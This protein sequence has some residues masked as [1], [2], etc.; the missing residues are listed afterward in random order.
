MLAHPNHPL[1]HIVGN[2]RGKH[3]ILV[4]DLSLTAGTLT[5]ASELLKREGAASVN[6][7]VTHCLLT[8]SA[9]DRL[10][11]SPIDHFLTTDSVPPPG[12][13]P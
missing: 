10:A 12:Y 6:A 13:Q 2:V 11:Q 3:V 4:D 5:N 1:T 7:F 8:K 9:L